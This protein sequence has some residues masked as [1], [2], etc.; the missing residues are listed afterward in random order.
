MTTQP[1]MRLMSSLRLLSRVTSAASIFVGCLVL[2]GWVLDITALK[3]VLPG[4]VTMKA[5]TAVAFILAGVSLWILSTEHAGLRTRRIASACALIVALIGLLTLGEY[6]LGWDLGIDQLLIK[7]ELGTVGTSAPGRMAPTT[8]LNFFMIGLALVLLDTPRGFR[9]A[10]LFVLMA[11]FIGLLNFIGYAYGVTLLYGLASYTRMAVHTA[12]TF[13]VVSVGLL[14]ARPDRG[15]I[16]RH[17]R[18]GG[19]RG[20][21]SSV[22]RRD[23]GPVSDR[24]VEIDRA[25]SGPVRH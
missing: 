5:N 4:F 14:F 25:A 7:E 12:V 20:G 16:G 17:Q 10:Q 21:P 8:A 3:S 15:L 19:R 2:A 1:T 23:W 11:G 6:L 13:V 24:L 18:Y 22:A 9:A